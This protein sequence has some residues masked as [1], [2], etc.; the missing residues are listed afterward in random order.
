MTRKIKYKKLL[1]FLFFVFIIV[2][3]VF[4][5]L[6]LHIANIY[7]DGNVYLSDQDIIEIANLEDYPLAFTTFSNFI[8]S[9]LK[10]NSKILD[11]S[12]KKSGT[13]I[14]ISV[15]ENRP[16]FYD[17]LTHR[18]VFSDG[19]IG[20][21]SFS[22]P[23]LT[24]SVNSSIYSKF[25]DKLSLI[26]SSVFSFISEISYCPNDVDNELFLFS[27]NDGNYVYMNLDRFSSIDRYFDMI[28]NFNGH[29]GILYLD[30]G[31]YFKILDN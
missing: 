31:E 26:N 16:L 5:F 11:A 23:V 1:L 28:V 20:D 13:R 21:S 18:V 12:V 29:K 3:C 8:E 7:V 30:S 19:S 9:K 22:V 27:M 14:N 6:T 2:F 25:L 15:V 17:E 4:K 10:S 24:S